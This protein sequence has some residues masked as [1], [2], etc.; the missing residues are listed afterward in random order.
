MDRNSYKTDR[1]IMGISGVPCLVT[2]QDIKDAIKKKKGVVS[3]VCKALPLGHA[4][5]YQR[6]AKDKSIKQ[7]LD[8]ARA[9]FDELLCDLSENVLT[10]A[11]S[12]RTDMASA[13]GASKYVLNNKGRIRGYSPIP[14]Q[15]E[16]KDTEILEVLNGI[17][18]ISEDTRSKIAEQSGVEAKQPIPHCKQKRG[19]NK[20]SAKSSTKKSI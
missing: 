4:T 7:C 12:Q 14:V 15:S 8:E 18:S 19:L 10:D 13:L 9:E 20:V 5:F 17:R 16:N 2:N 1:I 11:M 3:S 6:M